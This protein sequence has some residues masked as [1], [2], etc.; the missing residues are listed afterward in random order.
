MIG[1]ILRW[2]TY[3]QMAIHPTTNLAVHCW[4][5]NSRPVDYQSDPLMTAV[6]IYLI[7]E[8]S[9]FILLLS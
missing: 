4:E 3:P 1:Y 9:I 5:L 2:F 7:E 6:P 8:V